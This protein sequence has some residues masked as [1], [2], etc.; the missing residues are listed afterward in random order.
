MRRRARIP[1]RASIYFARSL[2]PGLKTAEPTAIAPQWA[3]CHHSGKLAGATAGRARGVVGGWPG[4][5]A[6]AERRSVRIAEHFESLTDPRRREPTY[7][8]V[9][10]VVMALCAV[11]SGADDF[12]AI[13]DW[14]REKKQ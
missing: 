13:A 5:N 7:P 14:A 11:L 1:P 6:V 12:V 3:I 8:L 4:G 9:N 10:I 2:A